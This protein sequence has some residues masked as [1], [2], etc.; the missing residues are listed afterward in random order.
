MKT[1]LSGYLLL[2]DL[3]GT[4]LPASKILSE[5]DILAIDKF[6]SMGGKFSIATGR[7]YESA[8]QYF[9][10]LHP[11]LPIILCNGGVI[12]D[13]DKKKALWSKKLPSDTRQIVAEMIEAFPEISAE[14]NMENAIYVIAENEQERYHMRISKSEDIAIHSQL[15]NVPDGWFKVLF[16]MPEKLIPKVVDFVSSKKYSGVDFVVSSKTFYEILPTDISKGTALDKLRSDYGF[17]KYKIISAGDYDNDL[18]MIK[19]ADLGA[20]PSSA[21]DIVKRSSNVV[22]RSSCEENAIA[23]LIEYIINNDN[24]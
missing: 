17:D 3:D 16:A 5:K 2:T 24:F 20:C 9:G 22:L 18:T 6:R 10:E 21:Q 1:N 12:Y 15:E 11:D 23:E 13:C 19:T 4:L 7:A 14:I 8:S